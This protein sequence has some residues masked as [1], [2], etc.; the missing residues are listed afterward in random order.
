MFTTFALNLNL[1]PLVW[2]IPYLVAVSTISLTSCKLKCQ[3]FIPRSYEV[4]HY[5][6]M[7]VVCLSVCLS[8]SPSVCVVPLP[9]HKS[10][11]EERKTEN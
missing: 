8:V 10:R 5:A 1:S 2:L 3:S 7:T 6:L 9:D 11:T 4:G